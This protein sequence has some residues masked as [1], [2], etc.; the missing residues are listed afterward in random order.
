MKY[1][2]LL[3]LVFSRRY[4]AYCFVKFAF[5][6]SFFG[7][8]LCTRLVPGKARSRLHHPSPLSSF[9]HIVSSSSSSFL[10]T[11]PSYTYSSPTAS[12]SN[13]QSFFRQAVL[14]SDQSSPFI[15][16]LLIDQNLSRNHPPTSV[17]MH[18]KGPSALLLLLAEFAVGS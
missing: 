9:T 5:V 2:K 7:D 18:L 6:M 14:V 11:S 15:L 4:Y 17:T 1:R 16:I 8:I 3:L 12:T 13:L 10:S